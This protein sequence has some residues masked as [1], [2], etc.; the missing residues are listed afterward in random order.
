MAHYWFPIYIYLDYRYINPVLI[1]Y[2]LPFCK[3]LKKEKVIKSYFFIRYNEGGSHIRIRF[4]ATQHNIDKHIIPSFADVWEALQAQFPKEMVHYTYAIY[5]PEV[6]RYGGK[7]GIALAEAHFADSSQTIFSIL[8]KNK[9]FDYAKALGYAMQLHFSFIWACRFSSSEAKFLIQSMYIHWFESATDFYIRNINPAAERNEAR[10][11]VMRSF[12]DSYKKQAAGLSNFI[13]SFWEALQE[14][15]YSEPVIKRWVGCVLRIHKKYQALDKRGKLS[16]YA[17]LPDRYT[18][19]NYK[20]SVI[21]ESL[22]HMTN[23]RLGILNMDEGFIGFIM[24]KLLDQLSFP[25]A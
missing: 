6:E 18:D 4:Y 12:E 22:F 7:W 16:I 13:V 15:T 2:L 10:Q 20:L 24:L 8:R 5:E 11:T 17:E 1:H 25:K 21:Y 9:Q 19:G 14:E 23:N 3:Q